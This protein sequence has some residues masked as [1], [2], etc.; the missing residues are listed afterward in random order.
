MSYP[1]QL[2]S[3][4]TK[5]GFRNP[6]V[7]KVIINGGTESDYKTILQVLGKSCAGRFLVTDDQLQELKDKIA[8]D[9]GFDKKIPFMIKLNNEGSAITSKSFL[10]NF[11]TY[12]NS[13][14]VKLQMWNSS[15]T[16]LCM[17]KENKFYNARLNVNK[18]MS[19]SDFLRL[20]NLGQIWSEEI[21]S[22]LADNPDWRLFKGIPK[23]EVNI[24]ASIIQGF[25]V[26]N[27]GKNQLFRKFTFC[28][29][30]LRVCYNI[31]NVPL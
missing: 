21:Q 30:K 17:L 31:N 27:L 18:K 20:I 12:S 13:S 28:N 24:E 26:R 15:I 5:K 11:N 16:V 22:F 25:F 10:S 8:N 29:G 23:I 3:E 2:L 14:V 4:I 7:R 6:F 1:I 9:L 19:K